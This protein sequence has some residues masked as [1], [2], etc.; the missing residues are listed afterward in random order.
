MCNI[1]V[2]APEHGL[3]TKH[4]NKFGLHIRHGDNVILVLL[5]GKIRQHIVR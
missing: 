2:I 3:I 5:N 1:W 4:L